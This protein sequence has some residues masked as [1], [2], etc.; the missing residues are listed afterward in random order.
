M[1]ATSLDMIKRAMRLM[2]VLAA[3]QEPSDTESADG[4]Y[5]LNSMT[6][7]LGIER[8]LIYQVGQASYSWAANAASKTIGSGGD[9]SAVRPIKVAEEGNFVR[10][11]STNID[12]PLIW[13]G[14]RDDYDRILLKSTT[15]TYPQWI[16]VDTGW[17]LATIYVWPVPTQTLELHLNTWTPLQTF[18]TLTEQLAM[19][20]GYQ[21]A[22]EYN[23]AVWFAPEFGTAATITPEVAKRAALLL[24]NLRAMNHPALV[25][26]LN[27]LPQGQ[28]VTYNIYSDSTNASN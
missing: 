25:A 26:R 16:F 1:S 22:I 18:D 3:N 5:A 24:Q 27:A 8:G 6:D 20:Q 2:R 7:A 11:G 23:L 10:D 15:S 19:P 28:G 9:F 13:M 17:P 21:A 12:Y 4:L 14:D